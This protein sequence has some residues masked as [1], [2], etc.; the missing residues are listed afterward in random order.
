MP[1]VRHE[2]MVAM[3]KTFTIDSIMSDRR[4][5]PQQQ[6]LR[7]APF[8][9]SR[10]SSLSSLSS[11]RSSPSSSPSSSMLPSST[12]PLS[13]SLTVAV[14]ASGHTALCRSSN[15]LP[16]PPHFLQPPAAAVS[17]A[18]Y[19]PHSQPPRPSYPA[20]SFHAAAVYPSFPAAGLLSDF[21]RL[22]EIQPGL[23]GYDHGGISLYHPHHQNPLH[24][25]PVVGQIGLHHVAEGQDSLYS[26]LL[27][28]QT[29]AGY[30]HH[31]ISG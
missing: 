27:A 10:A 23:T 20:V 7:P 29:G 12:T 14:S 21:N 26:W 22:G 30:F 9:S 31:G 2:K 1:A 24:A 11:R 13:H 6:H 5:T 25:S 18:F 19:H 28:R 17:S 3:K 4:G 8:P 16:S 15:T